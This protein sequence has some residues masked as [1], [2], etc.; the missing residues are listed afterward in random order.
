MIGECVQ[1]RARAPT[2]L[3]GR[4]NVLWPTPS[5]SGDLSRRLLG[6]NEVVQHETE[7]SLEDEEDFDH[8]CELRPASGRSTTESVD[9]CRCHGG[10]RRERE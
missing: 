6:G 8:V 1:R 4:W 10:G 5:A 3:V 7:V 9:D 2:V